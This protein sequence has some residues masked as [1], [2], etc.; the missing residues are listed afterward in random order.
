M[1]KRKKQSHKL[2]T[3]YMLGV[4]LMFAGALRVALNSDDAVDRVASLEKELDECL[5]TENY[6]RAAIIRDE[7]KKLNNKR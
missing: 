6:E 2:E 5:R 4:F 1:F 7:L 3:I